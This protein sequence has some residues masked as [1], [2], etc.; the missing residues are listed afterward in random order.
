LVGSIICTKR[1]TSRE[2]SSLSGS[3]NWERYSWSKRRRSW[4]KFQEETR[5]FKCGLE[6][7]NHI[8]APTRK[9]LHA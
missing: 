5:I 8:Q 4:G 9:L 1:T 2:N 3:I 6:K 7:R